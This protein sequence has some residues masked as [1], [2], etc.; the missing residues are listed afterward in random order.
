MSNLYQLGGTPDAAEFNANYYTLFV[1]NNGEWIWPY[2]PGTLRFFDY[3]NPVFVVSDAAQA[4][5]NN[6]GFTT[7]QITFN[8]NYIATMLTYDQAIAAGWPIGN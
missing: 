8:Q 4:M 7:D 3:E 6:S 5:A 2:Q 1:Y